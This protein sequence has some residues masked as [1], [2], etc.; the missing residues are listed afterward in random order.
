MP[1]YNEAEILACALEKLRLVAHDCSVIVVDGNSTDQ[2]A[3]IARNFFPTESTNV[4]SRGAQMDCGSRRLRACEPPVNVLL[5]LHADSQ[6]PPE[7][8]QAIRR[9][10]ADPRVVGGC[11]RMEFESSRLMLRIYSWF[12]RFP[13]RFLHFGDQGYFVRGEIF[14]EMGGYHAMPFLEDVDFQRRL[15]RR[16]RF[17]VLPATILTSARRFL[18]CGIVRQQVK[19]FLIVTLFEL[20]V[21]AS[22]L[23]RLYSHVR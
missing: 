17:L 10:L 20:G 9:A 18:R 14:E 2:T 12:T 16:G 6:L 23:A 1:V 5:F 4:P 22:R 21:P 3:S 13:G 8:S 19:N 11:F 7:F 15:R